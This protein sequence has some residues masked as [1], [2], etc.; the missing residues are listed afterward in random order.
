MGNNRNKRIEFNCDNCGILSN[1]KPSSY[2]RYN[3]HFCSMQCYS[4]FRKN[5]LPFIEQHAYKGVRSEGESKQIYTKRYYKSHPENIS[6]LKARRYARER[7]AEGS[8]TLLEWQML[9]LANCYKCVICGE[10]KL[11]TKDHK[12]PL[13]KGGADYISNIQPLCKNCNS[14][15]NT[16]LIHE[17]PELTEI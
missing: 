16:K 11:L 4:L 17:H 5:K 13:S 3:R 15:K 7:G 9:K 8:H 1:D 12:I 10:K 14:K 6:H 2:V